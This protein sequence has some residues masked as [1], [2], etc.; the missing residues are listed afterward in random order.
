MKHES[1]PSSSSP[2][3]IVINKS[4]SVKRPLRK[5]SISSSPSIKIKKQSAES[6]KD[7]TN[8]D[9]KQ[10]SAL[11]LEMETKL[12]DYFQMHCDLCMHR[13]SSWNDARSHYLDRHNALKPFLRCCNRKYFFR[14]RII[15]HVI[16][17]VDPNY[18]WYVIY[19]KM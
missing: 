3:L 18:F 7:L 6:S 4:V 14:S 5:R 16:W 11:E 1:L 19:M 13:F 10:Y 8:D 2:S 17:H 15:E 12:S 9:N